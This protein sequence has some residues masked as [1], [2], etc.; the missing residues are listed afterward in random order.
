MVNAMYFKKLLII[1]T[2]GL[3]LLASGCSKDNSKPSQPGFKDGS[4]PTPTADTVST[5]LPEPM[6]LNKGAAG[7]AIEKALLIAEGDLNI[8]EKLRLKSIL[9]GYHGFDQYVFDGQIRGNGAVKK[10][11]AATGQYNPSSN[12]FIIQKSDSNDSSKKNW[13]A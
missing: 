13:V 5:S 2:I 6:G 7:S 11:Y 9:S 4:P 10:I 8:N 1:T 12:S 3:S